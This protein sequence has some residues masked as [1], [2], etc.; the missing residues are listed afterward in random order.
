MVNIND[1][2]NAGLDSIV[3]SIIRCFEKV[4]EVFG[5]P[6]NP[7]MRWYYLKSAKAAQQGH[8]LGLPMHEVSFPPMPVP[9]SLS[10][11]AFGTFPA[12]SPI[13]KTFYENLEDGFYNFYIPEYG[14]AQYL[15]DWLSEF[16]QIKL[17]FCTDITVLNYAQEILFVL[18]SLYYHI[19]MMRSILFWF[20]I[21]NPYTWPW[22]PLVFFVDWTE[23]FISG[24]VPAISGINFSTS[25][26]LAF[27]GKTADSLNHLVLTMPFLPSEGERIIKIVDEEPQEFLIFRYLP[28]LWYKHP[29]PNEIREFW[30]N[31]RPEVLKYMQETYKD[32]N[33]QFLP[34]EVVEKMNMSLLLKPEEPVVLN[35]KIVSSTIQFFNESSHYFMT[36]HIDKL[37]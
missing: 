23:E 24:F 7:G 4:A 37:T 11:V 5:Y 6:E 19:V 32:L 22:W 31:D 15:P 10:E 12:I 17:N 27:L 36:T 9:N 28:L 20:I 29:I 30:Y 1:T 26:F 18:I 34:D 13:E 14:N 21:I 8:E 3:N 25:I 16:I 35:D 2:L 33:I